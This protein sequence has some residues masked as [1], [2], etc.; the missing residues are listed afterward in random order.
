MIPFMT[1]GGWPG[2]VIKDMKENKIKT[3]FN[4]K[5]KKKKILINITK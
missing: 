3:T 2:H 5:I 4:L 1:N